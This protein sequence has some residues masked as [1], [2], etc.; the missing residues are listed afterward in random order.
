MAPQSK[1]TNPT[2]GKSIKKTNTRQ[3]EPNLEN[4]RQNLEKRI[5]ENETQTKS[6][7][8]TPNS[9][10]SHVSVVL[11]NP[12]ALSQD[13]VQEMRSALGEM[14]QERKA[15]QE[16]I[17]KLTAMCTATTPSD[18]Q[19]K[20][21]G[22]KKQH[23]VLMAMGKLN[24]QAREC[25]AAGDNAMGKALQDGIDKA[26]AERTKLLRIADTS[27]NGWATVMEYQQNPIADSKADDKKL[28]NAEKTASE[29]AAAKASERKAKQSRFSPY[30]YQHSSHYQN[31]Q[32]DQTDTGTGYRAYGSYKSQNTY[33]N[34][35]VAPDKPLPKRNTNNDICF[36]CG[37]RGHWAHSCPEKKQNAEK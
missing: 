15:Q 2:K 22:N 8:G 32:D 9:S 25:Y 20:K 11:T 10:Q 17:I 18:I 29:K 36:S 6:G 30:N 28:R 4:L 1:K 13:L 23:E 27:A 35:A 26:I 37:G 19:W 24:K 21:D 31:K 34:T 16:K 33:R 5:T 12:E 14:R 3:S 7:E